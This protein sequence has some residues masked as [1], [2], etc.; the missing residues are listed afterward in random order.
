M[1]SINIEKIAE[2]VLKY[3]KEEDVTPYII[4]LTIVYG[5]MKGDSYATPDLIISLGTKE[6][7]LKVKMSASYKELIWNQAEYEHQEIAYACIGNYFGDNCKDSEE[8][9]SF[10][11]SY[12]YYTK[13]F[14]T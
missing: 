4:S 3:C 5:M 2:C 1:K 13:L 11:R 6:E 8:Y 14:I 9:Y 12:E 10:E 7:I